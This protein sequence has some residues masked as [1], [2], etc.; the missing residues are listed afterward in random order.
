ML[1]GFAVEAIAEEAVA[2]WRDRAA[3]EGV[4]FTL[5]VP[6]DPVVVNTDPHAVR[7]T[8]VRLD[9]EK[10]G[11]PDNAVF[12]VHDL[13]SDQKFHW[14]RD[15]YVRLDAFAEPAHILHITGKK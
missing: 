7:E 15:N 13:I 9:M 3:P 2:V 14:A 6:A 8:T 5:D 12:E 1:R 10:L 11:L 4:T